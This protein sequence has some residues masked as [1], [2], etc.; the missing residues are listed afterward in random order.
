MTNP[1]VA[2]P[3]LRRVA[4][5]TV[6]VTL[7]VALGLRAWQPQHLGIGHYDEG[8]YAISA[9]GLAAWPDAELFPG[10]VKFSPPVW[11]TMM[12]AVTRVAGVPADQAALVLNVVIGTA[13]AVAAALL[14]LRWFGPVA[15]LTTGLL[16][17]TSPLG[18]MLSRSGLTDPS[19]AL[20]FL[21][22]VAAM[23][24]AIERRSLVATLLAGFLAGV[25]W[26]TKYHG[27]FVL[28]IG[29]GALA[30]CMLAARRPGA[31]RFAAGPVLARLTSIGVL[32]GALYLPWAIYMRGASGGG[33][34][35]GMVD[36]YLSLMSAEWVGTAMRHAAMQEFLDGHPARLAVPLAI[37]V[38]ALLAPVAVSIRRLIAVLGV[39]VVATWLG[40]SLLP[41]ALLAAL[42]VAALLR[43]EA[44]R[45]RTGV[46][47]AWVGLWLVAAPFYHPYA[48]LILPLMVVLALL[49]G[50]GM[51]SVHRL[52]FAAEGSVRRGPLGVGLA[53]AAAMAALVGVSGLRPGA[54]QPW[55]DGRGT[56]RAA[57]A[58]ADLVPAG[59][60]IDVVGEPSLVHHLRRVGRDARPVVDELRDVESA[61]AVRHVAAGVYARRAPVLR[62]AIDRLRSRSDSLAAL[63]L[64]PTDLRLLDDLATGA[65][66]QWRRTATDEFH[67]VIFRVR[68]ASP[69]TTSDRGAVP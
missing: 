54:A 26:N 69:A 34:L 8:V 50:R 18:V 55:A 23:I 1:G 20:A 46:L 15:G 38:T 12:A 49:A 63:P 32:A 28:V 31:R 21:V 41:L 59:E 56:A 6:L 52:T 5:A 47:L 35:R 58:L 16:A 29:V 9:T 44:S 42:G 51:T 25:A 45:Y 48:R 10:Q 57:V 17:A 64:D 37:G 24:A 36:Y 3:V 14:A 11:I 61:T 39:A 33:G 2:A 68:P 66:R 40:G 65:A 62:D 60:T 43:G 53:T 67:V 4:A 13:L 22:A 30:W 19:F 27:W 7:V